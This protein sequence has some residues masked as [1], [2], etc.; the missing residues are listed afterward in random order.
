MKDMRFGGS[1]FD[2]YDSINEYKYKTGGNL[3]KII[4]TENDGI[5]KLNED[6]QT[7]L[8]PTIFKNIIIKKERIESNNI[9]RKSNNLII[10]KISEDC[11]CEKEKTKQEKELCIIKNIDEKIIDKDQKDCIIY[12]FFKPEGSHDGKVWL[13]NTHIDII[14]EQL[15]HLF[16]DYE[17]GFIHMIDNVMIIP[18][19]AKCINHRVRSITDIDFEDEVKNNTLKWYGVVYNTDTSDRGGQHWFAILFNFTTSGTEQDPYLIEYFNSSGLNIENNEFK[20]FLEDIAFKISYNTGKKTILKKVTNIQHQKSTTGNCGIYSLY[21]IWSRLKGI[22]LD[23]F[24]DPNNK[25]TD[26][27]MEEF[28]KI[29]FREEE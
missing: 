2:M 5:C 27:T 9:N 8:P 25:I 26:K 17:Y 11:N 24:N 10:N 22:P 6:K 16:P 14:Q 13:N 20:E 3:E 23:N 1:V 18:Q 28:R 15:Y 12:K 19:N 4:N 7:C 21:F 29:M